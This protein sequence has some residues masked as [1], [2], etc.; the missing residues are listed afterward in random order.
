LPTQNAIHI[1]VQD[2]KDVQRWMRHFNISKEELLTA[3]DQFGPAV[4]RISLGLKT[5]RTGEHLH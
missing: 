4:E 2:L 1:N 3:V 5:R